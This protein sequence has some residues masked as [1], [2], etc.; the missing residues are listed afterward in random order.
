MGSMSC[1]VATMGHEMHA[2]STV[3]FMQDPAYLEMKREVDEVFAS[4]STPALITAW[5]IRQQQFLV[6]IGRPDLIDTFTQDEPIIDITPETMG[7]LRP[8]EG[9]DFAKALGY[10]DKSPDSDILGDGGLGVLAEDTRDEAGYGG[11]PWVEVT[12]FNTLERPQIINEHGRSDVKPVPAKPEKRGYR[13]IGNFILNSVVRIE[14]QPDRDATTDIRILEKRIGSTRIL[15]VGDE[16][17]GPVYDENNSSNRRVYQVAVL[18]FAGFAA[19]KEAGIDYTKVPAFR[20]NESPPAV[21][22]LAMWDDMIDKGMD[23]EEALQIIR[24][25]T[26]H[27]NHTLVQAA[28][29]TVTRDQSIRFLE[30]N[31]K[32]DYAQNWL[33]SRF[34]GDKPIQLN[35]LALELAGVYNGVSNLHAK[36]SSKTFSETL[37]KAITFVGV[38]NAIARRWVNPKIFAMYNTLGIFKEKTFIVTEDYKDKLENLDVKEMRTYKA[39]GRQHMLGVLSERTDNH[40]KKIEFTCDDPENAKFIN[41]NRRA[42]NYKRVKMLLSDKD[43]LAQT[44]EGNNAY[45]IIAGKPHITDEPMKNELSELW[46]DIDSHPILKDRVKYVVGYDEEVGRALA[47]GCDVAVN[48]PRVREEACGTSWEKDLGNFEIL[49][50][51]PD[52]GAADDETQTGYH[53]ISGNTYEEEIVSMYSQLDKAL[54]IV[55]NDEQWRETNIQQLKVF[56]PIIAPA[57]MIK[58]YLDLWFPQDKAA[59]LVTP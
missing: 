53:V 51:T 31:L 7:C 59:D 46:A 52:G 16:N 8:I 4:M 33:A 28:G 29:N 22:M 10:D 48:V 5:G 58:G 25:K 21:M 9:S 18:G 13:N 19:L 40:G 12:T 6:D 20:I 45:L 23:P 37:S 30:P 54:R 2:E 43:T 1:E 27:T 11:L 14:N 36:E 50:S 34:D 57:R 39:E 47:F 35:T 32:S 44:L 41:W 15:A 42:A 17:F 55:D 24:S 3:G 38:T 26:L 49:V 56:A